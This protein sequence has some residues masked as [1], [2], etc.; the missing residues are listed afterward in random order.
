[1][2]P[3]CA[4]AKK[5]NIVYIVSNDQGWKDIGYHG[6]NIKTPNLDKLATDGIRLSMLVQNQLTIHIAS[7]LALLLAMPVVMTVPI[8]VPMIDTFYSLRN[9]L[10]LRVTGIADVD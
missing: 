8:A 4:Q 10:A 1:M 7:G 2:V 9:C 3:A 5:P 6:S